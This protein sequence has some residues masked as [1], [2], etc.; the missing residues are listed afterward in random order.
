MLNFGVI[1]PHPIGRCKEE[2]EALLV[3]RARL[4]DAADACWLQARIS[5]FSVDDAQG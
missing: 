2:N 1:A 3:G 4:S 5:I